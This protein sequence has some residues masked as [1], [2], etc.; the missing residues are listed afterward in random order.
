MGSD[1]WENPEFIKREKA[2]NR[3]KRKRNLD[4]VDKVRKYFTEQLRLYGLPE[5]HLDNVVENLVKNAINT[6]NWKGEE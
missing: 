6:L 3:R 4:K 2:E 1:D 5:I